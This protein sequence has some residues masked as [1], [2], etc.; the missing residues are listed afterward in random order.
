MEDFE[1]IDEEMYEEV[2]SFNLKSISL[3]NITNNTSVLALIL[4]I[5]YLKY[6]GGFTIKEAVNLSF[7]EAVKDCVMAAYTWFGRDES[8]SLCNTKIVKAI[9]GMINK[10]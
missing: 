7:K 6:V 5:N 3:Q 10:Y 8:K 1:K 9:Y 4:Q 2:V